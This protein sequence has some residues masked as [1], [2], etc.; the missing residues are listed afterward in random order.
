MLRDAF[1]NADNQRD[2]GFDGLLNARCRD[3]GTVDVS[4]DGDILAQSLRDEDA[5]CSRTGFFH[6]FPNVLKD[7]QSKVC[8]TSFLRIRASHNVCTCRRQLTTSH[9]LQL[10]W[11][12][13]FDRLFRMKPGEAG[14]SNLPLT[15]IV[16]LTF[17][18]F[19]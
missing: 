6:G 1:R 2:L 5:R 15:D 16:S 13:V 17:P 4:I 19:L 8:L 9:H 14:Q 10:L 7:W 18:V 12:T 11:H 3:W